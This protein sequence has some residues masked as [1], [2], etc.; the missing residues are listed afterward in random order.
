MLCGTVANKDL[1]SYLLM[2]SLHSK[3]CIVEVMLRAEL[4]RASWMQEYHSSPPPPWAGGDLNKTSATTNITLW[5]TNCFS[6]S[7]CINEEEGYLLPTWARKITWRCFDWMIQ[8]SSGQ[9]YSGA[10]S[11]NI[12]KLFSELKLVT[13]NLLFSCI[14]HSMLL[15]VKY[16]LWAIV[17]ESLPTNL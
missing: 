5:R 1:P 14:P 2:V 4:T 6:F 16:V 3:H 12:G 17:A 8:L 10:F 9:K 7:F 13:D 11:R 15:K